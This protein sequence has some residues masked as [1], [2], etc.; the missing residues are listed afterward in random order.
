MH[1][2]WARVLEFTYGRNQRISETT[3]PRTKPEVQ[4][5][6]HFFWISDQPP[7]HVASRKGGS[8]G[9]NVVAPLDLLS[10]PC[11]AHRWQMAIQLNSLSLTRPGQSRSL[12]PQPLLQRIFVG[13]SHLDH[14]KSDGRSCA[15]GSATVDTLATPKPEED[16]QGN[17]GRGNRG[18][19]RGGTCGSAG[20]PGQWAPRARI[21]AIPNQDTGNSR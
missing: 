13:F 2:F 19:R 4:E 11:A 12:G 1:A 20:G 8:R 10:S 7:E 21:G 16:G 5:P 9:G 17:N 6:N 15:W 18:E 3:K 14:S